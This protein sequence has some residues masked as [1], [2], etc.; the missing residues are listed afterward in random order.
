MPLF[1][2]NASSDGDGDGGGGGGGCTLFLDV[3][4]FSF[5]L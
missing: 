4:A 2:R 5:V 1:D 3:G